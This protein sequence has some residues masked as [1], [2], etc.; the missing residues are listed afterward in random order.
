M[1]HEIPVTLI[2]LDG[3]RPH[4]LMQAD[5]PE[6]KN[7]V[8]HGSHTL[9][10]RTVFPSVT[11][12]CIASIFLGVS[13]EIHITIGNLWNSVEWQVPGLIDLFHLAGGRT[14][15]FYKGNNSTTSPVPARSMLPSALT[16][17]SRR[18]YRWAKTTS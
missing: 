14:A 16:M 17:P 18:I 12:P 10:A 7:L 3:M 5:T 9:K 11:L 2:L 13:P 8:Q 1:M 4:A 6:M 15:A